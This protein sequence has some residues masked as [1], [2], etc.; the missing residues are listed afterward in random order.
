VLDGTTQQVV[1]RT[2]WRTKGWVVGRDDWDEHLAR[3][4]WR[5]MGEWE[6]DE[7]GFRCAVE[8]I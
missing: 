7:L 4:G 8:R 2:S 5:R 1:A 6:S 3:L